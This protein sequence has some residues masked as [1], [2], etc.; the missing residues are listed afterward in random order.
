MQSYLCVCLFTFTAAMLSVYHINI[1]SLHF[2]QLNAHNMLNTYIYL[3]T[4]TSSV[5]RCLLHHLQGDHCV[6]YSKTKCFSHGFYKMYNMSLY[7]KFSMLLQ[8]LESGYIVGFIA[9]LQKAHSSW[10][11]KTM[12]SL[13]VV[14][15]TPKHEGG[16]NNQLDATIIILLKISISPTCFGR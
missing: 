5:F 10:A 2:F 15:Q 11:N 12:V 1:Q 4:V 14:K 13:K 3:S 6:I 9:T 7:F 16:I 8:S